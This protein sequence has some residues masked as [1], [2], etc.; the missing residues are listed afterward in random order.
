[1]DL[2]KA[3]RSLYEEKKRL[4]RLIQSLERIQARAVAVE[5]EKPKARRGRR[6]M[7]AGERLEVSERMKRYWA[8]R[9]ASS[10]TANR[11]ETTAATAAAGSGGST[12][13]DAIF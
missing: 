9:R 11:S 4:D 7:S 2:Y 12:L 1:M 5:S 13:P 3:I 6:G 10:N 8:S